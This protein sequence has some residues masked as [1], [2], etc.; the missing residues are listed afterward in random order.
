MRRFPIRSIERVID[1]DTVEVLL[2]LGFHI[3]TRKRVR[4]MG[5][6]TPECRTTDAEEKH[7]GLLA[8]DVLTDW[9][10]QENAIPELRCPKV[11]YR[12]KFGRVLGQ[13]WINDTNINQWLCENAYAVE[14][15]GKRNRDELR[16]MHEQNRIILS[17]KY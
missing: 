4:L 11:R 2:D 5:I 12:D 16:E 17:S 7:Y 13:L 3:Y 14:Y 9:C 10:F 6:D 15:D 1:G 8:K